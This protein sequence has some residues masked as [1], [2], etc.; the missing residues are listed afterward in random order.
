MNIQMNELHGID[1]RDKYK[2]VIFTFNLKSFFLVNI[3][4]WNGC[5]SSLLT[6]YCEF[7]KFENKS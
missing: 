2:F 1:I 5:L 7:W 6:Y 3:L 4:N